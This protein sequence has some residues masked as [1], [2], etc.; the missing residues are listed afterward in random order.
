MSL[1]AHVV[2]LGSQ[3]NHT[4]A[5]RY[6]L[7]SVQQQHRHT[8]PLLPWAP[9]NPIDASNGCWRGWSGRT[10]LTRPQASS[11]SHPTRA[12]SCPSHARTPH[13]WRRRSPAAQHLI[14]HFGS[15]TPSNGCMLQSATSD[16]C[17]N[18]ALPLIYDNN[19][20]MTFIL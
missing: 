20:E 4:R 6:L 7:T 12:L 18:H 11:V 15:V 19:R 1:T 8:V 17:A 9:E 13:R 3:N 14:R 16:T 10:T 2:T 5:C